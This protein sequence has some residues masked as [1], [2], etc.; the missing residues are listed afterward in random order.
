MA[1][2]KRR[3]KKTVARKVDERALVPP[4]AP[5]VPIAPAPRATRKPR[6]VSAST[7]REQEDVLWRITR[8]WPYA[9]SLP[10][11]INLS[12]PERQGAGAPVLLE[13]IV[14]IER[15]VQISTHREKEPYREAPAQTG[16]DEDKK[17]PG[18]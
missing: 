18:A 4:A 6:S 15:Q 12:A 11:G 7:F 1:T 2:P 8:A 17:A 16:T 5:V 9:G 3:K 10:S 13:C 14:P